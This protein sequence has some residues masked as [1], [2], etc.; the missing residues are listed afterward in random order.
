MSLIARGNHKLAKTVGIFNLPSGITCPGATPECKKI[1]YAKKP[2]RYSKQA[3]ASRQSN[4]DLTRHPDFEDTMVWEIDRMKLQYFRWHESGD[5]YDQVYLDK[6]LRICDRLPKVQFLMYTKSFHLD[7]KAAPSNLVI[8]WSTTDSN[9]AA[10]PEGPKAH[11]VLKGQTPPAGYVTCVHASD[12]GY[13]A[14]ECTTC[15]RGQADVYFD[16]H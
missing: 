2:E 10:A 14:R 4:Y 8:Y 5:A 9:A 16:Q 7:F 15:W 13:C 11:I 1:C 6:I 12:S 3:R